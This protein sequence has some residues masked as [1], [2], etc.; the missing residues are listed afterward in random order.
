MIVASDL[1]QT[2][3]QWKKT[4]VKSEARYWLQQRIERVKHAKPHRFTLV[5]P[6]HSTAYGVPMP[7]ADA[8]DRRLGNW[9]ADVRR[10][11]PPD[12]S[13]PRGHMYAERPNK[14]AQKNNKDLADI[15]HTIPLLENDVVAQGAR[16]QF[17]RAVRI[18]DRETA[19]LEAGHLIRRALR[20]QMGLLRFTFSNYR[21]DD[22][23]L[24]RYWADHA[25]VN[26]RYAPEEADYSRWFAAY[27]RTLSQDA[28]KKLMSNA[29]LAMERGATKVEKGQ[30]V[31]SK[32]LEKLMVRGV[33]RYYHH[34]F[35]DAW[36]VRHARR[37]MRRAVADPG[38]DTLAIHRAIKPI[39]SPESFDE[40][41]AAKMRT[42]LTG[43]DGVIAHR[44]QE[45]LSVRRDSLAFH[46][47]KR[48]TSAINSFL[49]YP[50]EPVVVKWLEQSRRAPTRQLQEKY[51][52]K[53]LTQH[54]II[55]PNED[56]P[57]FLAT[58]RNKRVIDVWRS[59]DFHGVNALGISLLPKESRKRRI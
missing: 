19:I 53:A 7:V 2:D 3:R 35:P 39:T 48:I 49:Q 24:S 28:D 32:Y 12:V 37:L 6:I 52:M 9:A 22:L 8:T 26:G 36:A 38:L 33:G 47:A 46:Q 54:M 42:A 41:I 45:K 56:G 34:R 31:P 23:A 29:A 25:I 1:R 59:V 40:A 20:K 51:L 4:F 11:S 43:K 14:W 17:A 50:H 15:L 5:D 18:G 21:V 16:E 57:Q 58:N 10:V 27:L 13:Y 30:R 44:I 55:H